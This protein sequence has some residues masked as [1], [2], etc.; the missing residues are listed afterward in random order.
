MS[1]AYIQPFL[2]QEAEPRAELVEETL[3][4]RRQ[5]RRRRLEGR[6]RGH[7]ERVTARP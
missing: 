5:L 7:G 1:L 4:G 2:L 6:P 3:P